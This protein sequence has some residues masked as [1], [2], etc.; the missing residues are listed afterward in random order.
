MPEEEQLN[1]GNMMG[2][3]MTLVMLA[4]VAQIIPAPRGE[5]VIN[6]LQIS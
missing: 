4:L 6:S 3:M 5:L 2:M 1:I